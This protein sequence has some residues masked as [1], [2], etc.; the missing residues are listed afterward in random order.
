MNIKKN[1]AIYCVTYNSYKELDG[2]YNSIKSCL[3]CCNNCDVDFFVADNTE[4]GF[5]SIALEASDHMHPH[6]FEYH[7]NMGYFGAIHQMMT[8][9]EPSKY[10]YV[11]L[12]NVDVMAG[13]QALDSLCKVNSD[14]HVGWIAP[15][16]YSLKE[17]RDLNPAIMTRYSKNRLMA[18]RLLYKYP[19]LLWLYE[20]TLYKRKKIGSNVAKSCGGEIYAGHGSFIILTK[21]YIQQ[22]GIINYPVF[23]YDEELYLAEECRSHG[24]KVV[25]EPS[26]VIVDIGK[27]STGKMPS[28]FYCKCNEEGINYILNKYY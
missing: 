17:K 4:A 9:T 16:I 7:K 5:K 15:Q 22:C 1:I 10:D 2:Y 26:I 19:L 21:E 24:L 28:D 27:V 6:V 11:I 20:N 18:L 3:P 12:S 8:E 23:L 13:K 25:H 14:N